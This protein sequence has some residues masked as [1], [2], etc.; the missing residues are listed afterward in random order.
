MTA[1]SRAIMGAISVTVNAIEN[2]QRAGGLP[3]G[4][5]DPRICLG[6]LRLILDAMRIALS[7]HSDVAGVARVAVRQSLLKVDVGDLDTV[8]DDFKS[9]FRTCIR[10]GDLSRNASGEI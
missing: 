4:P 7:E 8:V 5:D 2:D 1:N 3:T 9:A 6:K 10:T